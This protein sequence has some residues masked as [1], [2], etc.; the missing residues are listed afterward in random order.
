MSDVKLVRLSSGEEL[1]CA[2]KSETVDGITIEDVTVII[3]TENRNIGLAP[4]MPYAETDGMFIKKD[5][6]AFIIDPV[7]Q[8]AEQHR[9]IHSKILTPNQKIVY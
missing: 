1:L 8:L 2:M 7:D 5:Y 4:W 3:P 9:S 6:V